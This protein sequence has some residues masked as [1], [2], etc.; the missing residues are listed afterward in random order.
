MN[1]FI[2][3]FKIGKG[4]QLGIVAAIFWGA[5]I[6]L[7]AQS[8]NVVGWQQTSLVESIACVLTFVAILPLV[9][10]TEK[11]FANVRGTVR[12]KFLLL[13]SLLQ[14]AGLL[15]LNTGLDKVADFAPIVVA[16]SAVYPAITV[17]LALKHLNEKLQTIHL[18]G[19]LVAVAGVVI[20][21]LG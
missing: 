2:L 5:T 18:A 15:A 7:A 4:P 20:L 3:K 12:N 21:S 17:F 11:V 6:A 9:R 1:R 16:V 14:L 13:A 8:I 10:G 19:A